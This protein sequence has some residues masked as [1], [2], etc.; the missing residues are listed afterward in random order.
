ML[1][2]IACADWEV[3]EVDPVEVPVEGVVV[4][5]AGISGLTTAKAL[6]N[7]GV[8]VVVLEARDRIGGR[9]W[10][11]DVGDARVDVGGAWVHGTRGSVTADVLKELDIDIP[12]D[13]SWSNP[14]VVREDGAP[15]SV[16]DL[17]EYTDRFWR[18]CEDL[19]GPSVSEAVDQWIE[20]E[21]WTG[22]EAWLARWAVETENENDTAGPAELI[23]LRG[24]FEWDV[25]GGG[26]RVPEGG[27]GVLIDYLAE[28]LDVRLEEPVTAIRW[29]DEG[30]EVTSASGSIEAS[31]VVVTV[32]LGVLKSGTIDFSP[33]LPEEKLAAIER[34]DMANL[35]KVVLTYDEQWWSGSAIYVAEGGRFPY[36][37]DFTEHA[38]APTLVCLYGGGFARE[39]QT[40]SDEELVAGVRAV[41]LEVYGSDPEPAATHVTHWTT[42]PFAGGS[43]SYIA[44]GATHD[45]LGI[46][47]EPVDDRVLFAGE[48]TVEG[49]WQSVHGAMLSGLR[50]A[51]RLGVEDFGIPGTEGH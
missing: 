25:L 38:G 51:R 7:N 32:P 35:E 26:D 28:G 41:L 11:T 40:D 37:A 18:D 21:G 6:Q 12:H 14:V 45:D 50:E 10:T 46:L 47:A 19:A 42:D 9:T 22:D 39:V 36:C 23:D 29:D 5:G 48:H 2:L 33:G 3:P 34:L 49:Q 16:W 13:D 24:L 15:I 43:Y 30:V 27:Y 31:A 8:D 44:V 1:F 4:V 17:V 20:A